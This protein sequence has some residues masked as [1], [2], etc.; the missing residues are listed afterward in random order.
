MDG[1]R[2][3]A[4]RE[5]R[6]V[7]VQDHPHQVSGGVSGLQPDDH[8][9][10]RDGAGAGDPPHLQLLRAARL[11]ALPVSRVLPRAEVHGVRLG[12]PAHVQL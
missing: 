11:S 12:G 5:R 3:G 8:G 1:P 10:R 6:R 9:Q 2:R 4:A 7:R